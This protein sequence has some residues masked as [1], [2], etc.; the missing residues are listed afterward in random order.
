MKIWQYNSKKYLHLSIIWSLIFHIIFI[1]FIG[2]TGH[3]PSIKLNNE[4]IQT[5]YTYKAS[6]NIEISS[7]FHDYS[8]EVDIRNSSDIDNKTGIFETPFSF[9]SMPVSAEKEDE[10]PAVSLSKNDPFDFEFYPE[11]IDISKPLITI[12]LWIDATGLVTKTEI[13]QTQIDEYTTKK[14]AAKVGSQQFYPAIKDGKGIA[15]TKIYS[16]G[17]ESD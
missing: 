3:K 7:Q 2:N 14:M 13:L 8:D 16:I 10:K 9:A 4:I 1:F 12:K 15:S 17:K 6:N 5:V 11:N